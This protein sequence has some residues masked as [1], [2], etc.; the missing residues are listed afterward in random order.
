VVFAHYLPPDAGPNN[1]GQPGL[2]HPATPSTLRPMSGPDMIS[3][4]V[5]KGDAYA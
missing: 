2:V 4:F 5:S 3:P 1:G